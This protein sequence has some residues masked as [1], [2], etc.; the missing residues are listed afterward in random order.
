M[1]NRPPYALSL[2]APFEMNSVVG[3]GRRLVMRVVLLQAGCALL[4]ASVFWMLSGRAAAV[5]ALAGGLIAAVGSGVFGWRLFAPGIA[6]AGTLARA[7]YAGEALK[8]LWTVIA[9]WV[10]LT[11]FKAA[12]LALVTGVGV[13]QFGYWLGLIGDKQSTG[14]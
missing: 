2:P 12:P 10:A 14:D 6:A 11:R 8:W 4:V 3:R 1:G 7:L 5:S 13:A 9:L